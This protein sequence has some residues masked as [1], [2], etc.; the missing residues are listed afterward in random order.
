MSGQLDK[1]NGA[2][3]LIHV[4]LYYVG[5]AGFCVYSLLRRTKVKIFLL[6]IHSS[7]S[8]MYDVDSQKAEPEVINM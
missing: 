4:S 7:V 5:C 1:I 6:S 2:L 3:Y 8:S